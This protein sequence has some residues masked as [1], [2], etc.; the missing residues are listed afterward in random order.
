ML[1]GIDAVMVAE[2]AHKAQARTNKQTYLLHLNSVANTLPMVLGQGDRCPYTYK[3]LYTAAGSSCVS[4]Q[5]LHQHTGQLLTAH[6]ISLRTNS[7]SVQVIIKQQDEAEAA[8]RKHKA[9]FVEVKVW[10]LQVAAMKDKMKEG[11]LHVGL[12]VRT[13]QTLATSAEMQ[14]AMD[15]LIILGDE[16]KEVT[17]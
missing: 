3:L 14:V 15:A 1:Q 16:F 6:S 2:L 9:E 4:P 5:Q 8:Y 10:G 17:M 12:L 7:V 11:I 13:G